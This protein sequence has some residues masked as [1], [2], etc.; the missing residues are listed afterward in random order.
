MYL[1]TPLAYPYVNLVTVITKTALLLEA[2]RLGFH[3]SVFRNNW[4]YMLADTVQGLMLYI[5]YEGLLSLNSLL[6]SPLKRQATALPTE[7]YSKQAQEDNRLLY[8]FEQN[9]HFLFNKCKVA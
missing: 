3:V 4:H 8:G 9:V 2:I 1:G 5:V 7:L 6:A